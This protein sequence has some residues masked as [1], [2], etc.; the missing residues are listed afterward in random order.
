MAKKQIGIDEC[1]LKLPESQSHL[2]ASDAAATTLPRD[3]RS[4]P[5]KISLPQSGMER[6]FCHSLVITL[7]RAP[8]NGPIVFASL[9]LNPD[10][11][12][13]CCRLGLLKPSVGTASA[14]AEKNF[15]FAKSPLEWTDHRWHAM[16]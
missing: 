15:I 12:Q 13:P 3:F 10:L 16:F 1:A 6:N 9:T 14:R 7:R 5:A 8:I 4:I 11:S 2:P